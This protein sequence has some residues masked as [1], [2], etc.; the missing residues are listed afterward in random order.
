M[1]NSAKVEELL[2]ADTRIEALTGIRAIFVVWLVAHHLIRRLSMGSDLVADDYG[3]LRQGMAATTGFLVLAGIL[4]AW[5]WGVR[6]GTEPGIEPSLR[7]IRRRWVMVW[8]LA[9]LGVV[10]SIPFEMREGLMGA[11]EFVAGLA[12]NLGMLQAWIP[13]GGEE[14]GVSLRFNAP[15]WTISVLVACY[16]AFPLVAIWVHR[17]L[18]T[19]R[20]LITAAVAAW[21]A[22]VV[23]TI[24]YAW[25]PHGQ[26]LVHVH[27]MVRGVDVLVGV[28]LGTM[29]VRRGRP[30]RQAGWLLQV[31]GIAAVLAAAGFAAWLGSPW[32]FYGA[33]YI[34]PLALLCVSLTAHDGPM[35]RLCAAAPMVWAGRRAY[36]L[37]M[38]HVPVLGIAWQSGLVDP[39]R[40]WSTALALLACCV[41]A[42]AAHRWVE[43]PVVRSHARR[44]CGRRSPMPAPHLPLATVARVE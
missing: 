29:V 17:G 6:L 19:T 37:A 40:P 31:A 22:V 14:H 7:F 15:T 8:P 9:A 42:E 1:Q 18:R 2:V 3:I 28:L 10:L 27:P 34:P 43:V 32:K 13:V 24:G 4:L 39:A 33:L 25:E 12:L 35:T 36:A 20:A 41:V 16:A 26:W 21:I 30:G 11:R 44:E 5:S 23:L 38:V